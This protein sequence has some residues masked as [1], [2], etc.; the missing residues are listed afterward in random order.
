MKIFD[1]LGLNEFN[2][3][4]NLGATNIITTT[5]D[6]FLKDRDPRWAYMEWVPADGVVYVI[7]TT[8]EFDLEGVKYAVVCWEYSGCSPGEFL[9]AI[10]D[11]LM[12]KSGSKFG[13]IK[14]EKEKRIILEHINQLISPYRLDLFKG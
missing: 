2:L 11:Y 4:V 12:L 7:E 13:V 6:F 10:P 1:Q 14:N 3:T 9:N 5:K 8:V